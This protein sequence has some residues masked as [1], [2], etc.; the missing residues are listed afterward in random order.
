MLNDL[1][2][3]FFSL[4]TLTFLL[5]IFFTWLVLKT[6]KEGRKALKDLN[7]GSVVL[8]AKSNYFESNDE[9]AI[10]IKKNYFGI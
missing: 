5:I 10:K 9:L 7:N 6:L 8:P 1:N 4:I 2:T 3:T